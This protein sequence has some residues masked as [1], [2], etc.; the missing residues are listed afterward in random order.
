MD[1]AMDVGIVVLVVIREGADDGARF[2]RRGS[3]VKVDEFVA[4]HL[5]RKDGEVGANG[6]NVEFSRRG[7]SGGKS[8]ISGI[9]LQAIR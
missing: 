9:E 7:R 3:V 2:L 6:G 1:A 5:A 8:R 4:V